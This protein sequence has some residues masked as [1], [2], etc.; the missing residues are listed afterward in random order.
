ML[1]LCRRHAAR[2]SPE[3]KVTAVKI[4]PQKKKVKMMLQSHVMMI[5]ARHVLPAI[6]LLRLL[7]Q[8]TCVWTSLITKRIRIFSSS[9]QPHTFQ[10]V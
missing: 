2:Q 6:L 1:N 5:A 7:F 9:I 10:T 8:K 3:R 4:I